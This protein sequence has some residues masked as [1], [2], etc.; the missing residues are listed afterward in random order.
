MNLNDTKSSETLR[1]EI[2]HDLDRLDT[3]VD[4]L[5]DRLTPGQ[6]I[7]DAVFGSYRGNPK[8]C[9]N[10]LK[11]NPLGTSFLAIGTMLLLD[12]EGESYEHYL[13]SQS[14]V[15][16]SDYKNKAMETRG[17]LGEKV[18]SISH[19]LRSKSEQLAR[20]G[21]EKMAQLKGAG[22]QLKDQVKGKISSK[23]QEV[24]DNVIDASKT[25]RE[26]G[27]LS[28]TESNELQMESNSMVNEG[29]NA[30]ESDE[31]EMESRGLRS[32][33]SEYGRKASERIKNSEIDSFTYVALGTSMGFATGSIIPLSDDEIGHSSFGLDFDIGGLRTDLQNAA[34]ESMN[35]FKNEFIDTLKGSNI[36][37]F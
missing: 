34:N 5:K 18:E 26:R 9:F 2:T 13:R 16:Y 35:A 37:L 28:S 17:R 24:K 8:A 23:T 36:D 11:D 25:F 22:R 10:Y 30:F 32:K 6:I 4:R 20:Q 14:R 15:V 12:N 19:D 31:F 27:A 7:D 3:K 29:G 21:E 1:K 33:V